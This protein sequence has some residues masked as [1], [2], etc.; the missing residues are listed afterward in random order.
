MFFFMMA[1]EKGHLCQVVLN[2]QNA[3][4]HALL[5]VFSNSF[6]SVYTGFTSLSREI[7]IGPLHCLNILYV[8][9]L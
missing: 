7:G 8:N 6:D 9:L 4:S 3:I 5:P 2:L 1:F